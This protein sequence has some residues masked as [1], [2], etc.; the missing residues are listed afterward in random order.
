MSNLIG[1]VAAFAEQV[2]QRKLTLVP[3]RSVFG[4]ELFPD[5]VLASAGT[6]GHIDVTQ[7]TEAK[8]VIDKILSDSDFA[9]IAPR[10]G[11]PDPMVMSPYGGI[12]APASGIVRALFSSAFLNMYFLGQPLE[13]S[14][15][16]RAVLEGLDELRRAIKG[17]PVH[18]YRVSG[19][20]GISVSDDKRIDLPWGTL[21]AAPKVPASGYTVLQPR[22]QTTCLLIQSQLVPVAFDRLPQ[23]D[24][25]F[26]PSY[27]TQLRHADT[28]F[29]L[30]CALASTD[31]THPTAAL[32]TWETTILPF[33]SFNSFGAP[34]IDKWFVQPT[35]VDSSIANVEEWARIIDRN[36]TAAVDLAANR[37]LSAIS[38]RNDVSDSLVDAVIVWENLL[39]TSHEVTFRVSAALAKMIEAN[40]LARRARKK[41]LTE[42]YAVRSKLVHGAVVESNKITKSYEIAIGAA[43][44]ALRLS[45]EKGPDWLGMSSEERSNIILLEWP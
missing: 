21:R 31:P 43:I 42:V 16:V 8:T 35:L 15:Y 18:A 4:Y 5:A 24:R 9:V 26:D 10:S 17:A 30:S 25:K 39:G 1:V 40:P 6:F 3:N 23:P 14:T 38:R 7:L 19:V 13:E 44:Q 32:Q 33:Q 36:H 28:L 45:Y 41:E 37:L 34:F 12:R 29:P 2:F 11:E 20:A 22:P 27:Q